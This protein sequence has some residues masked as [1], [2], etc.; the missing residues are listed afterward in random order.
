MN[1][2]TTEQ[3]V[4]WEIDSIQDALGNCIELNDDF[5]TRYCS[6]TVLEQLIQVDES[7]REQLVQDNIVKA[8]ANGSPASNADGIWIELSEIELQIESEDELDDPSDW[9]INRDCAYYYVGYGISFEINTD[10]LA[11]DVTEL[12][13]DG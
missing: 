3:A 8:W 4:Q 9:T 1:K 13:A 5:I 6:E 12:L 7:D 11:L 10:K 2:I